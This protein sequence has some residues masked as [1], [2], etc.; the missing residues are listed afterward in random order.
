MTELVGD[1]VGTLVYLDDILIAAPDIIELGKRVRTV[2]G[3]LHQVGIKIN[4][5]KSMDYSTRKTW[6]GLEIT[7]TRI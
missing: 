5:R 4:E 3:K 7:D 1:Y 2:R 6:S